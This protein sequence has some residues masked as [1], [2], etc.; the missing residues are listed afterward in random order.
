MTIYFYN[1]AECKNIVLF[2]E[3]LASTR[4]TTRL[5]PAAVNN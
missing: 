3:K 4:S 5:M 1:L 2:P